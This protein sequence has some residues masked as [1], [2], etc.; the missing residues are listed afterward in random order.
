MSLLLTPQE[1]FGDPAVVERLTRAA[2]A[3]RPRDPN[4]PKPAPL[5]REVILAAGR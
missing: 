3:E 2:A 4:R 5:T 1:V